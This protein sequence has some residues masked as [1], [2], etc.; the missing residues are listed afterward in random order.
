MLT[1]LPGFAIGLKYAPLNKKRGK[2]EIAAGFGYQEEDPK[3]YCL[4]T[5]F[6]TMGC[7]G[8]PAIF[9]EQ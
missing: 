2:R 4:K 3:D 1:A 8:L 6:R 9:W 7:V 5:P